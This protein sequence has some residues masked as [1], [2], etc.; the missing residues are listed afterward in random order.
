MKGLANTPK[1]RAGAPG[2]GAGQKF[3]N[4][5]KMKGPAVTPPLPAAMKAAK[6]PLKGKQ[7]KIAASEQRTRLT[8]DFAGVEAIAPT[9]EFLAACEKFG[10]AFEGED[11]SRLGIYLACLIK[12]NEV[13]NLTAITNPAE[14]WMRHV[15]DALTLLPVFGELPDGARLIDVGTGGGIPGVPLAICLPGVRVTLLEATGKKCEYLRAVLEA[16]KTGNAVVLQGR[17]ETV[18]HDRGE[19]V[20]APASQGGGATR[21]GGHR[22]LYDGVTARAVAKLNT[23]TELLVPFAKPPVEGA[24]GGVIAV[25]KGAKADEEVA[26]AKNALHLLKAVHVQTVETPTGK[27]MI[28]EKGAAT[29]RL[30][31]RADGEPS[32][33]PL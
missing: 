10:I 9:A 20:N 8:F 1:G 15:F 26:E 29:P 12:A 16:T 30:Y 31:P 25:I 5:E 19:K 32:H 23:L 13:M 4:A 7:A 6:K 14:A 28:F 22:E 17:A 21:A 3:R 27:I 2:K 11:L 18:A 33:R 24:P